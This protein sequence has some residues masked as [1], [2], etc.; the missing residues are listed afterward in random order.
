MKQ[1]CEAYR[2]D[3]FVSALLT[4]ISWTNHLPIMSKAKSREER[5]FYAALAAK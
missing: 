3:E 5:D 4:Q 2:G 1:F